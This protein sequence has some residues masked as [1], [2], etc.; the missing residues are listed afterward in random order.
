MLM[1]NTDPVVYYK[2]Y[3]QNNKTIVEIFKNLSPAIPM[4][5]IFNF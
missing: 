3:S 4:T 1:K 5:F 2:D